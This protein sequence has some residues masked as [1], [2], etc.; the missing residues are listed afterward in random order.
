MLSSFKKLMT[1]VEAVIS[2]LFSV[3]IMFFTI[4]ENP[5][6]VV[7]FVLFIISNLENG[8]EYKLIHHFSAKKFY[9]IVESILKS[10][11]M[12]QLGSLESNLFN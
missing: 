5:L 9:N 1:V 8:T 2:I 6:P 11:F 4:F 12:P 3:Q 7:D 10:N